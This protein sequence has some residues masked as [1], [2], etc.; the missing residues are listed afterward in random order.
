MLIWF[1]S[2]QC[3]KKAYFAA[4]AGKEAKIG[5]MES[6]LFLSSL[7]SVKKMAGSYSIAL[8]V[9]F[10]LL[11]WLTFPCANS[12]SSL[13]PFVHVSMEMLSPTTGSQNRPR[14]LLVVDDEKWFLQIVFSNCSI[15]SYSAP[16][17]PEESIC[18]HLLK[19]RGVHGGDIRL[20]SMPCRWCCCWW[21]VQ[22]SVCHYTDL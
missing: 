12:S 6:R 2:S 4:A 21:Q 20:V 19:V 7:R 17:G 3:R 15:W 11:L 5:G 22:F 18:R 13:L 1:P 10:T 14:A 9:P 8:V 16:P